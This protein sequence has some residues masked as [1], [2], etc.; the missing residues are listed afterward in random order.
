MGPGQGARA[1]DFTDGVWAV[2]CARG[3]IPMSVP[4]GIASE[5]FVCCEIPQK[6]IHWFQRKTWGC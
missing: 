4:I 6:N 1:M 2:E 3:F 5:I